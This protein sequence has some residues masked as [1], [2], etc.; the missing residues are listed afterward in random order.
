MAASTTPCRRA[1]T[2]VAGVVAGCLA[3]VALTLITFPGIAS[4]LGAGTTA[5]RLLAI[6]ESG[7][8]AVCGSAPDGVAAGASC[9]SINAFGNASVMAPG[10]SHTTTLVFTNAGSVAANSF[11][12]KAGTCSQ[13]RSAPV[14]GTATDLC[15]L[16]SVKLATAGRTVFEGSAAD[17][18][19]AG[20]IDILATA[21]SGPLASGHSVAVTVTLS[22]SE[23]AG[24]RHQGLRILAPISWTFGA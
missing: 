21:G 6:E 22:L 17:F 13:V 15:D 18:G 14:S 24:N 16:F 1:R 10:G 3:S 5:N 8:S 4:A 12:V 11:A 19:R 2:S 9:S 23:A 20:V 7:G